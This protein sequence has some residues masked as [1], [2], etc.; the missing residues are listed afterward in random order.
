[1]GGK[2]D[3]N[4]TAESSELGCGKMRVAAPIFQLA[5]S[6]MSRVSEN[7]K[8]EQLRAELAKAEEELRQATTPESKLQTLDRLRQALADFSC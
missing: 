2:Q 3:R 7:D 1:V 5:W 8:L 4:P 6:G